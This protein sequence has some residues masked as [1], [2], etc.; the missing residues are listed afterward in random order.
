MA[1]QVLN[2]KLGFQAEFVEIVVASLEIYPR[3]S[4]KDYTPRLV[5]VLA[6]LFA[7]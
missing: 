2:S 3:F 1:I 4:G 5:L 6:Q 7:K